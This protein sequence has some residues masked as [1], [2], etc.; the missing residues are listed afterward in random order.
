M[1]MLTKPRII[2]LLLVTTILPMFVAGSPGI[3]LVLIVI[4]GG[5]LL[6]V[7]AIAVNF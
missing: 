1:V 7:G 6:A 4:V 5:Y 3:A 2:S